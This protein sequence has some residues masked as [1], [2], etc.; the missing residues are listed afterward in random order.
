MR[1]LILKSITT[2]ALIKCVYS[3]GVTFENPLDELAAY[4][5]KAFKTIE[6]QISFKSQAIIAKIDEIIK[7]VD[8]AVEQFNGQPA[9]TELVSE[10]LDLRTKL[11]AIRQ[12]TLSSSS[13]NSLNR[14]KRSTSDCDVIFDQFTSSQDKLDAIK[15]QKYNNENV[16]KDVNEAISYLNG[17]KTNFTSLL[18]SP[19]WL[20]LVDILL[21]LDV[22]SKKYAILNQN[23]EIYD[24][25]DAV[26]EQAVN[27]VSLLCTPQSDDNPVGV[28]MMFT[29]DFSQVI[30]TMIGLAQDVGVS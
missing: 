10:L 6:D 13:D 23:L 17:E 5:E 19:D 14:R 15:L 22:L 29:F 16:V 1:L 11:F 21:E 27:Q 2:L 12:P 18:S 20:T 7:S 26:L 25:V 4:W 3:G 8:D 30:N 9:L 28:R 24:R